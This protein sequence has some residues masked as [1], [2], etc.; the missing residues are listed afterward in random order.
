MSATTARPAAGARRGNPLA[1]AQWVVVLVVGVLIVTLILAFN[2][3][4]RLSAGQK[5]MNAA[6]PAFAAQR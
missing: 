1:V 4:P 2:L 3:I 6:R 5:V